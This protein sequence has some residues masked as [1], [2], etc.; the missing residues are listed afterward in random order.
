MLRNVRVWVVCFLLVSVSPGFAQLRV[1]TGEVVNIYRQHCA[2]CHGEQ[3]DG[4][5]GGS[6]ISPELE[7][8][9]DDASI[10]RVIRDGIPEAGMQAFREV[11]SDQEM[12]ALVIYIREMRLQ[13]HGLPEAQAS[14]DGLY[15]SAHHEFRVDTVFDLPGEIWAMDFLPDGAMLVAEKEGRLRLVRD[16]KPGEPLRGTPEVWV[17]GQGGLMGIAVH[18]DHA[19]NGWVYL[20]YARR[21][22]GRQLR[23]AGMTVLARG[24]IDGG[25]WVDHEVL[26]EAPPEFL[27][28]SRLHFGSRVVLK[29]GY[30]FF[31]IGD[32]GEMH[33]AQDLGSP[34]GKIHRLHEDGRVPDDNPFVGREGAL[35][36]IWSY[37]HRN[38][39]GLAFHPDTG[40]LWSSEHGP[41]GGDELNLVERGLN[42]GWP[43]ITHGMNY[44]GTP[45]THLTEKE[46]MEQP[47]LH[48]TPS[49]AV[50]GIDFYRGD[51][52]PRWRHQLF[53]TGLASEQLHRLKISPDNE[54][55]EEEIILRE[56]GRL[57][58]VI[59]GPDG[60]LYV[61]VNHGRRGSGGSSMLRILPVER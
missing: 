40:D 20:T 31:P 25:R 29:D 2:V 12:R 54:V 21:G 11:L 41:R 3:M 37:G 9:S 58:H 55:V 14:P 49:I 30:L 16:G 61:A 42:Y 53:V 4:G 7:Y 47:V 23:N 35:A 52:F 45:L 32:R 33:S 27:T 15:S 26:W 39:Q 19:D 36:S 22:E 57:R 34:N 13:A 10:L 1:G 43:V 59:S 17:H 8:G 44:N 6:L 38:P 24:R 50:C 48:W 56:H 51:R 46:G 60:F 5:L 18:P 28:N